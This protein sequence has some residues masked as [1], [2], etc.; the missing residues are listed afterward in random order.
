MRT[1]LRLLLAGMLGALSL[2]LLSPGQAFAC[3]C[4]AA[5]TAEHVKWADVVV[6]GTVVGQDGPPTGR[7]PSGFAP[8]TFTI[9]VHE[10]FKGTSG[11]LLE[12]TTAASGAACGLEGIRTGHRYVVFASPAP[13][14]LGPESEHPGSPTANLCGGTAP[15]TPGLVAEV[16]AV[17][18]P[19]QPPGPATTGPATTGPATTG[20]TDVP[21]PLSDDPAGLVGAVAH[22]GG[23]V[24]DGEAGTQGNDPRLVVTLLAAVGVAAIAA[25]TA[26]RLRRRG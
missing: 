23:P 9:E 18:G 19:G 6:T 15:A 25:A 2:V 21:R 17:T 3:S 11:A 7:A 22:E 14:G 10:V 8:V 4:V 12:V 13:G 5:D 26:V 16:E 1:T 24:L 20:G